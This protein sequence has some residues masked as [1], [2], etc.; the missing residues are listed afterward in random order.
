M[1]KIVLLFFAA[2]VMIAAAGCSSFPAKKDTV[3]APYSKILVRPLNFDGAALDKISGNELDEYNNARPELTKL[4]KDNFAKVAPKSGYFDQILFEGTPDA[5]TLVL[6]SRLA[7]LDPGIR[8]VM[9]GRGAVVCELKDGVTGRKIGSYSVS[10]S[11]S[12]PLTST[13]M[14]AIETMIGEMGED[15]ASDIGEAK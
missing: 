5:G 14:G 15:A 11:V 1:R 4:F 3:L 8:W 7:M 13:M 9:P 10:R 2:V 6:E 12:R